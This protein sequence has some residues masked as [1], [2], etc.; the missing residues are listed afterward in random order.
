MLIVEIKADTANL[1]EEQF[2]MLSSSNREI[3]I[4]RDKNKNIIV[5]S[6]SGT[7]TGNY[8]AEVLGEVGKWNHEQRKGVAFY[9]NTGFILPNNAVRSPKGAWMTDENWA[10][11]PK[12]DKDRFPHICPDFVWEM[13]CHWDSLDE[14]KLRMEEW[15]ENGCRL[16]WL[17]DPETRITSIYKPKMKVVEVPFSE[18]LSGEDV[19]AGF[20][21]RLDDI[22]V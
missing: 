15:I 11:I 6:L 8:N 17:I 2:F 21:L 1:S 10:K 16:G 14:T 4:E 3:I 5:N 9:S 7:Q 19:L 13:M 18:M 12:S 20:E 22:I